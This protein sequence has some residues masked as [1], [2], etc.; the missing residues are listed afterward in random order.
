M[1]YIAKTNT[2]H[3]E[4]FC[5]DPLN[6]FLLMVCCGASV[7]DC[8]RTSESTSGASF[9][10]VG[11]VPFP[12]T[13]AICKKLICGSHSSTESEV[14]ALESAVRS[15]ALPSLTFRV[16]MLA[17]PGV[18][19]KF[20]KKPLFVW[21]GFGRTS[22]KRKH[23]VVACSNCRRSVG[24]ASQSVAKRRNQF[25]RFPTL[26]RRFSDACGRTPTL[27]SVLVATSETRKSRH[28]ESILVA[29]SD[30][31]KSAE[32]TKYFVATSGNNKI[33]ASQAEK[34]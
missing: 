32:N 13:S 23:L 1:F 29:T 34:T 3:K 11:P 15:E 9:V 2:F 30:K 33:T 26:L 31:F 25:R 5:G 17:V 24:D 20:S 8:S 6:Q 14:F 22:M 4:S 7:A 27:E 18:D 19:F 21:W 10:L 16:T 12:P 28:L